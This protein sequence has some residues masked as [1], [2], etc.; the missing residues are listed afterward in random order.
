MV[1][2]KKVSIQSNKGYEVVTLGLQTTYYK[3][4]KPH[5]IDGPAITYQGRNY[6]VYYLNGIQ[7]TKRDFNKVQNCPLKELPLYLNNRFAPIAKW[8]LENG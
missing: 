2:Y 4:G 5:R 1:N 6:E 3:D 7:V 8:R